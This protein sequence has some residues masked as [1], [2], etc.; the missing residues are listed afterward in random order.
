MTTIKKIAS[1]IRLSVKEFKGCKFSI[2]TDINK[3][4][5]A[6]IAAPFNAAVEENLSSYEKNN[7][8]F[9]VN[10]YYIKDCKKITEPAKVIFN[11][12]HEIIKKYHYDKSDAMIDYFDTNFY[13]DFQVGRFDKP[14]MIN[15]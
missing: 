10:Q 7:M 8:Y 5:V 14:F 3:I 4:N 13:Y 2:T 15:N 1:E 9:G 12:I 6:L 11:Q